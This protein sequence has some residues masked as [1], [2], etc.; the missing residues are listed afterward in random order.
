MDN[1]IKIARKRLE[2][3][4]EKLE[5][6]L[7]TAIRNDIDNTM[8]NSVKIAREKWEEKQLYVLFKRLINNISQEKKT[9][10]AKKRKL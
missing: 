1:R 5:G 2:G 3:F 6:R 9:D 8:D 10:Q 7:I 4:I